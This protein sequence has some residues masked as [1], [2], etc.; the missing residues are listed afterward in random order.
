MRRFLMFVIASALTA[1]AAQ[2]PSKTP[3]AKD[4]SPAGGAASE[5]W[6]KKKLKDYI[7]EH[8]ASL[9]AAAQSQIGTPRP[10]FNPNDL[11]IVIAGGPGAWM[12]LHRSAGGFENSFVTKKIE[13]PRNWD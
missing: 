2:G 7:L 11:M 10:S 1:V 5:R 12:G 3:P 6:T 9:F 13:L 8:A 4:D